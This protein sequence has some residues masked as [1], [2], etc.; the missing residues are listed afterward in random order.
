MPLATH[1]MGFPGDSA[2]KEST[3]NAED[4]GSIPGWGSSLGEELSYLLQYSWTF[5]MAQTVKNLPAMQK[6]WVRSLGQKDPL[7]KEM[8]P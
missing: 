4:L 7:E 1:S 2:G 6:T 8:A 3:C 5:L